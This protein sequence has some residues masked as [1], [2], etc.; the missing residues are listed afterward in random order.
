MAQPVRHF[1]GSDPVVLVIRFDFDIAVSKEDKE[2]RVLRISALIEECRYVGHAIRPMFDLHIC[3]GAPRL[4]MV[5][6]DVDAVAED[7]HVRLLR[8]PL[9]R[10]EVP[11]CGL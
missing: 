6:K 4:L 8:A 11:D 9:A 7:G 2:Q 5:V 1:G 3:Q 10:F